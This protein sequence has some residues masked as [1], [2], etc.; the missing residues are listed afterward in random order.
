MIKLDMLHFLPSPKKRMLGN[1]LENCVDCLTPIL[2]V[3]EQTRVLHRTSVLGKR[4]T[5]IQ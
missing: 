5:H 1:E 3:D 2:L 4:S